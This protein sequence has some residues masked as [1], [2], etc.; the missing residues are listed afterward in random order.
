VKLL[1]T[2]RD[3][4]LGISAENLRSVFDSFSPATRST[5][6]EYGG[7]GLG[8]SIATQLVE[9]MGGRLWAESELGEGSVFRFTIDLGIAEPAA[10]LLSAPLSGGRSIEAR[11]RHLRVLVAEDNPL[12]QLL[13]RELLERLG[14][15]VAVASDGEEALR[16]LS[17]G[18]FDLVLMDVQMPKLDG[19]EATRRIRAGL[20]EG[21]PADL[22]V[23]ALTAHAIQ[24]DRDRFLEA[25]MD[26]YLA[27]PFDLENL[28]GVLRRMAERKA[29]REAG[30]SA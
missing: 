3:T 1:F 25:G 30:A 23:V 6:A 28:G 27:K 10:E 26:D 7:T 12:N 14:H 29:R 4:G 11:D 16:V 5:H 13:A 20:V 21:C 22:P 9:L 17:A 19:D 8:L 15:E 24:G 18:P 2:V